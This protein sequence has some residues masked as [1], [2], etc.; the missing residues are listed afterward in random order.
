MTLIRIALVVV[1]LHNCK[2]LTK[3]IATKS[4]KGKLRVTE[5]EQ[6]AP[7]DNKSHTVDNKWF[8]CAMIYLTTY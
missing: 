2:T 8:S 6:D 4:L 3:T 1:S 7:N 5:G